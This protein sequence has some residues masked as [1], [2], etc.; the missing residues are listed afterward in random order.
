MAERSARFLSFFSL[1]PPSPDCLPHGLEGV[2]ADGRREVH[3]DAAVLVHRLAGSERIAEKGELD[4]GILLGPIV[5]GTRGPRRSM[6]LRAA[7]EAYRHPELAQGLDGCGNV[8]PGVWR[9][10]RRSRAAQ[11]YLYRLP[12][13]R[14][15][16]FTS[17][18]SS[19]ES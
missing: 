15:A 11:N 8:A 4:V 5:T 6:R 14:P 9:E 7:L 13:E 3:I 18:W 12:P 16:G 19:D 2:A 17:K 10:G 1:D